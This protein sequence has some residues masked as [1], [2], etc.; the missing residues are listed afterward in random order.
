MCLHAWR[1]QHFTV[2]LT[3]TIQAKLYTLSSCQQHCII[4][5]FSHSQQN[6]KDF[7]MQHEVVPVI[8]P[9]IFQT[10]VTS[11]MWRWF[12][13]TGQIITV[14]CNCKRHLSVILT[15]PPGTTA[16]ITAPLANTQLATHFPV[17]NTPMHTHNVQHMRPYRHRVTTLATQQATHTH[18][19]TQH[20]TVTMQSA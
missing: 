3:V 19:H 2:G 17:Q 10:S 13:E 8:V 16:T 15:R 5:C 6:L 14:S 7:I 9:D 18:T 1:N 12:T 11:M 20:C 4:Y